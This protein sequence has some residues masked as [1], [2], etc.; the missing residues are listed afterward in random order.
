M[1]VLSFIF[2]FVKMVSY[3]FKDSMFMVQVKWNERK[4]S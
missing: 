4:I 1:Y 2:K 3:G